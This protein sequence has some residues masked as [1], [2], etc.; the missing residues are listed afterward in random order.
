MYMSYIRILYDIVFI[1]QYHYIGQWNYYN[2]GSFNQLLRNNATCKDLFEYF[3]DLSPNDVN[4]LYSL[5]T[6]EMKTLDEIADY[7][8]KDRTTVYRCLQKLVGTGLVIKKKN[9]ID[10]GGYYFTYSRV[11]IDMINQLIHEKENEF[12][13]ASKLLLENIKNELKK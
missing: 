8:K 2:M 3:F 13:L 9:T 5:C 11:S 4:I 1:M 6:D 12:T 7:M 10:K